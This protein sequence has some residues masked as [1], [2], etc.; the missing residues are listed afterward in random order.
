MT[1]KSDIVYAI[2]DA[3]IVTALKAE[4]TVIAQL[5]HSSYRVALRSIHLTVSQAE[6][7][8]VKASTR[9]SLTASHAAYLKAANRKQAVKSSIDLHGLT[10]DEACR[11]LEAWLNASIV[12]NA[13]HGKVIHGLGTGR[14][15][16]AAHDILRR[17]SAVRAFRI[18]A[19]N[20][21]ETD[22]YFE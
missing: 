20:P 15:Q 11:S 10:V 9:G 21:G 18:N 6:I 12:S 7:V 16:Q 1:A 13:Q 2:G 22:V 3:V 4:G 5:A 19:A 8:P 14:V 17:Y